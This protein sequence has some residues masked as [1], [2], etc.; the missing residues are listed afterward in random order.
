M[1][2]PAREIDELFGNKKLARQLQDTPYLAPVEFGAYYYNAARLSCRFL[3]RWSSSRRYPDQL[4]FIE[5][6]F[7]SP[8][9]TRLRYI[10]TRACSKSARAVGDGFRE[11][12]RV[13]LASPRSKKRRKSMRYVCTRRPKV[14]ATV[15]AARTLWNRIKLNHLLLL[16]LLLLSLL[17]L[18]TLE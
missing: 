8:L 1:S 4:S 16:L 18:R 13:S 12:L 9:Y 7:K 15:A 2:S 5:H 10:G 17:L 11:E 3:Y 6:I 14:S